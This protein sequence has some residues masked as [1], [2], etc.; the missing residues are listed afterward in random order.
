MC[1]Y[2]GGAVK[3]LITGAAIVALAVGYL[4]TVLPA[5]AASP[6]VNEFPICIQTDLQVEPD[7]SDDI[8]VWGDDRNGNRDIYG[9]NLSSSIEFLICNNSS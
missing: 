3:K 4:A 8:V 1:G 9:Y 6:T 5:I 7:V 2:E